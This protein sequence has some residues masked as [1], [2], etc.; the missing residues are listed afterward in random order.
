MFLLVCDI[1][2]YL[3]QIRIAHRK[4]SVT[5][6]PLEAEQL[7]FIFEPKVRNPLQLFDPFSLSD[8]ATK[9][10][11]HVNVIFDAAGQDR[12]AT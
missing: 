2:L 8:G 11:E 9:T 6:L 3:F 10:R 5:A 7:V 12:S 1:P 4:I